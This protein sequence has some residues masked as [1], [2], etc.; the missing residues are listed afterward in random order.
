ML[1][2]IWFVMIVIG[3]FV[4]MLK[5]QLDIVNQVVINYT[6]EAVVFAIGLTG[7]MSVWLGL[8]KIAERSG[9]ID[10]IG[11]L[12]GPIIR[13]LFPEIP[14]NHPA[15]SAIMMNLVA[16]MFGAGNSATALGLK[17]MEELQQLNARKERATNAMCMF[18]VINMSSVQLVPLTV[19]KIRADAGSANPAEIIGTTLVATTVSTIVGIL[20]C[21]ILERNR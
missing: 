17:A 1:S 12:M 6:Q 15:I 11:K 9:L 8:M 2:I 18:L 16:N 13:L 5:G 19:L 14:S 21:K 10:T 7:I 20:S 4:A 3:I